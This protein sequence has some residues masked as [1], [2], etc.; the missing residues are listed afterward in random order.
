MDSEL[1]RYSLTF[2]LIIEIQVVFAILVVILA[3]TFSENDL[4]PMS[5]L[6]LNYRD[7]TVGNS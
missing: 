4:N 3:V 6:M 5:G 1:L 7:S 2:C